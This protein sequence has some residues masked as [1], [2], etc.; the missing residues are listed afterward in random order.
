MDRLLNTEYRLDEVN[1]Q[2]MMEVRNTR[3]RLLQI[4][5]G[6]VNSAEDNGQDATAL[7]KYRQE[8]RD[9]PQNFQNADDVIWP[10]KPDL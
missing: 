1:D 3:A 9:I 8:L 6:L 7:R 2:K 10:T 4:A 5:D